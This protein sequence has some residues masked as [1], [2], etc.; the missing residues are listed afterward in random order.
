MEEMKMTTTKGLLASPSNYL[1]RFTRLAE[2]GQDAF[3][4]VA[5][6]VVVERLRE[7]EKVTAS[8]IVYAVDVKN[9]LGTFAKDRPHWVRVLAVG[10]GH[11][12]EVTG[13]AVPLDV[14]PGDIGV[15][16]EVSVKYFSTFGDMDGCAAD[17]I[18]FTREAEF[19]LIFNGEDGYRS[20]FGLLNEPAEKE[21]AN[22][23]PGATE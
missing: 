1:T 21:V 23:T 15:V 13:E 16:A 4:L 20:A 22:D 9:Q 3:R 7:P 17:T 5:D 12:D 11:Y 6:I 18:G 14:K 2:Q 19:Q 8:G 10:N